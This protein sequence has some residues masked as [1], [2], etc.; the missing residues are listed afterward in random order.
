MHSRNQDYGAWKDTPLALRIFWISAV[1]NCAAFFAISG[2][3][4][5]YAFS[6]GEDRGK[7]F[8]AYQ[9][10]TTEVS[11]TTFYLAAAY[12]AITAATS[13]LALGSIVVRGRPFIPWSTERKF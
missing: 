12:A 13:F 2:W 1:I 6:G 4:G 8:V 9:R 7:Y 11:R 10:Q 5:G 3:I